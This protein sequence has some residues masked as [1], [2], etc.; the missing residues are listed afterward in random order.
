ISQSAVSQ[1]FQPASLTNRDCASNVSTGA[2]GEI[3]N[4]ADWETCATLK[5]C[6]Q[7]RSSSSRAEGFFGLR[8][9]DFFRPSD[10]GLRISKPSVT[11]FLPL[12]CEVKP[13]GCESVR[14]LQR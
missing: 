6:P 13:I 10:C 8:P 1:G 3:G 9:S 2:G 11:C 4:S 14:A 7:T 5:P 12:L